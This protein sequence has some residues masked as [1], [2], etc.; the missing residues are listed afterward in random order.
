MRQLM[1][2]HGL[3]IVL[4]GLFLAIW[5]GQVLVGRADSNAERATRGQPPR[6]LGKY[7]RSGHFLEATGENWE[8]EFLQ[9]GAF[10]WLT[11]CLFQIGSPESND[12]RE[13]DDDSSGP[14]PESPWPARRGGLVRAVY[15][16]SLSL[17]FAALFLF[18]MWLHALGGSWEYSEEQVAQGQSPVTIWGYLGTTR[19]WFES[20]Q[21]WQSEFL[22]IAS[23]VILSIFLRHKGSAESK[24]VDA[25]HTSNK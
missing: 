16:R 5:G 13:P 17:A 7:L 1:R 25:P 15:S 12:P 19:F 24:P 10:V 21:N 2:N 23:M 3:S 22:A 11:A 8:S 18:A 6:S 4:V 14:K 20:L 9:M